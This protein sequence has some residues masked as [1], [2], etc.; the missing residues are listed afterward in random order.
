[1]AINRNQDLHSAAVPF[2]DVDEERWWQRYWAQVVILLT[3]QDR[4]IED[5]VGATNVPTVEEHLARNRESVKQRT[6]ALIARA[7]QRLTLLTAGAVSTRAA[8][9][10]ARGRGA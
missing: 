10:L 6:E 2:G 4:E 5:L 3:A 9:D 7:Q 8:R 1:M